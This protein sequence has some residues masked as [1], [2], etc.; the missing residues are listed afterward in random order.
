MR[1]S[2][3]SLNRIVEDQIAANETYRRQVVE[4]GRSFLSDG[5]SMS[6]D[7][8]LSKLHDPEKSNQT[9]IGY[10]LAAI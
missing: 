3:M 10:R 4:S 9:E 7:D 6:D 2:T 8:L 1:I 5:R